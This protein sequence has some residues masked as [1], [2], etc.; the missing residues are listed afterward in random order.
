MA[1]T[2]A[3]IKQFSDALKEATQAARSLAAEHSNM[4]RDQL[5]NNAAAADAFTESLR[6]AE[7][8]LI[9]E[10]KVR[11]K[12]IDQQTEEA[13]LKK[14]VNKLTKEHEQIVKDHGTAS[15]K[16]AEALDRLTEAEKQLDEAKNKTGKLTNL[17]GKDF[18]KL[19]K[20]VKWAE[21]G[22]RFFGTAAVN[23]GKE[24]IK[25]YQTAGGLIEGSGSILVSMLEQQNLAFK[26]GISGSELQAISNQQRQVFNAMGGTKEA[27]DELNPAF[28]RFQIMTADNGLALELAAEAAQHFAEHGVVPTEAALS[29]YTDD[30]DRMRTRLGIDYKQASAMFNEVASDAESIDILRSAR[31]DEREAILDSQ[32]AYI[33]NAVALGMT[34]QQA[35]DAAKMLNKM[36]AAKPL[37]RLR[38]AAKIRALGG[39]MGIAG[40][41]EAARALIS[42]KK[43]AASKQALAEFN[44]NMTN[45]MDSMAGQ[46]LQSE[47]FASSLLE[48]LDLEQ[49]FGKSSPFSTTLGPSLQ[50]QADTLKN[51]QVASNKNEGII[52]GWLSNIAGQM[53]LVASGKSWVGPVAGAIV[54]GLG[55]LLSKGLV[56][57]LAGL[58]KGMGGAGAAEAGVAGGAAG[59]MWG[60]AKTVGRVLG[61]AAPV[62]STGFNVVEGV[63]DIAA[64]KTGSG[65]GQLAGTAIGGVIG[66][67]GGPLGVAV[68]TTIGGVV[69]KWIGSSFDDNAKE[70]EKIQAATPVPSGEGSLQKEIAELAAKQKERQT[71]PQANQLNTTLEELNA[72]LKAL[73]EQ[74]QQITVSNKAFDTAMNATTT[75]IQEA[76]A[77]PQRTDASQL[78]V[79]PVEML[80]IP[81]QQ[82]RSLDTKDKEIADEVASATLSTADG[83]SRQVLLMDT[84][85]VLLK[86]LTD[87]TQRQV[88]LSEKQLVA[89]T[90]T[91]RERTDVT[92]RSNLM[93]DN[94]FSSSYNYV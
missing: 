64:G 45:A 18:G 44:T 24:L 13:K 94:K 26:H 71:S 43:D 36:V 9:D 29:A 4:V 51:F 22:L 66:L 8:G 86:Q 6:D 63:S 74:V 73:D 16:A 55:L 60:K 69:G 11:Q 75:K 54:G 2:D 21:A 92:N 19:S 90:L 89:M 78:N 82:R 62:V 50:A 85:N 53:G 88:D 23:Q 5:R 7:T 70:A 65:T 39:A 91:E 33:E 83:V 35:K 72:R 48:K 46:G 59:G 67:L 27:L 76:G 40:S 12:L 47:I 10:E 80:P 87:L 52:I 84:S 38:Q 68:G 93:K 15:K 49:Y 61:R 79:K 57:N 41:E 32:R 25:H 17:L 58:L 81:A 30:L 1:M 14:E 42:G 77:D 31:A 34:A 56:K 3:E 20:G 37:D 28:K